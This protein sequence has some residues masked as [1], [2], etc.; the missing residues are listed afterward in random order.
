M[1]IQNVG[2]DLDGDAYDIKI[3]ANG[4]KGTHSEY[5]TVLLEV[6]ENAN[7]IPGSILIDFGQRYDGEAN[8]TISYLKHGT[9]KAANVKA[10]PTFYDIDARVPESDYSKFPNLVFN[11]REGVSFEGNTATCYI[12]QPSAFKVDQSKG[13]FCYNGERVIGG[14]CTGKEVKGAVTAI[15]DSSTFTMTVSAYYAGVHMRFDNYEDPGSPS[16]SATTTG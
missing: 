14:A 9:T 7:N 6:I 1:L 11:G 13:A 5:G 16:K 15:F 3:V 10:A 8:F 2:T 12:C 4:V